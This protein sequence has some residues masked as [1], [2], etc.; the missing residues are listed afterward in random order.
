MRQAT[1]RPAVQ[2]RMGCT[3]EEILQ[4]ADD[5][6]T[7]YPDNADHMLATCRLLRGFLAGELAQLG[8]DVRAS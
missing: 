6:M 8:E 4:Y 7:N 5:M 1:S 3:R 2:G